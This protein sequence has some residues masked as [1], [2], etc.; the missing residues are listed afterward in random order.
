MRKL[1]RKLTTALTKIDVIY[2][3]GESGK[4]ITDAELSLMYALDDGDSHSQ[5]D[6]SSEWLIP[7]TTLNTIVKRWE[8]QG[9]ISQVAITGKRREMSIFLTD[10]GEEYVKSHLERIYKAEEQAMKKT[11]DQFDVKFI[12]AVEA[13][14]KYL[15]E[16]FE[17]SN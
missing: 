2:L 16:A 15:K 17:E 1:T 9:L 12:D 4:N 5:R 10:S 6:I 3:A 11:L 13:Y 7:K 14:G 8:R